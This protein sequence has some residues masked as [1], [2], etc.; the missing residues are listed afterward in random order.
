MSHDLQN[1]NE[2]Q[3]ADYYLCWRKVLNQGCPHFQNIGSEEIISINQLTHM[4]SAIAGKSLQI[5]HIEGPQGVRG[6]DRL[7]PR[8]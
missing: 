2:L 3:F 4:V 1:K 8:D 5:N 7:H 6:G